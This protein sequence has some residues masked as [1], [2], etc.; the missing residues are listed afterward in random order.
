[1]LKN[2]LGL[3][4]CEG[5]KCTSVQPGFSKY[6]VGCKLLSAVIEINC[7]NSFCLCIPGNLSTF[8][9]PCTKLL[10]IYSSP[11]SISKFGKE[12]SIPIVSPPGAF[13]FIG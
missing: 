6:I 7:G 4:S 8:L 13:L 3:S 1:M 9:K 5:C 12:Y 10:Q 2:G 11:L